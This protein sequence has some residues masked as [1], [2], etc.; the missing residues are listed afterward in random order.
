MKCNEYSPKALAIGV[1]TWGVSRAIAA[2]PTKA[3][4]AYIL[5]DQDLPVRANAGNQEAD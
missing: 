4:S 5:G 2:I 3:A 1:D